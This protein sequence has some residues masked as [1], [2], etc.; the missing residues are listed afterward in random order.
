ME[1]MDEELHV[2]ALHDDHKRDIDA[3]YARGV[4]DSNRAWQEALPTD[5]GP[6]LLRAPKTPEEATVWADAY[7]KQAEDRGVAAGRRKAMGAD[8]GGHGP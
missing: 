3:A 4:A 1:D 8:E 2:Q 5:A 7:R 6:A